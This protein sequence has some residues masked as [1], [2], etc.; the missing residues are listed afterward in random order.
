[1]IAFAVIQERDVSLSKLCLVD[2]AN[3]EGLD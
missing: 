2:H 3:E 1:M